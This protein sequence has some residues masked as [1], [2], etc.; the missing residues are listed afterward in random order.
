MDNLNKSLDSFKEQGLL[1]ESTVAQIKS[2]F[3]ETVAEATRAEISIREAQIVEEA[4]LEAYGE[5]EDVLAEKEKVIMAEADEYAKNIIEES[6]AKKVTE[7]EKEAIEYVDSLEEKY[8]DTLD[9][10]IEE[11]ILPELDINLLE[12]AMNKV[13]DVTITKLTEESDRLVSKLREESFAKDK[14]IEDLSEVISS[15]NTSKKSEKRSIAEESAMRTLRREKRRALREESV[16]DDDGEFDEDYSGTLFNEDDED[17]YDDGYG[18]ATENHSEESDI[19]DDTKDD[20]AARYLKEHEAKNDKSSDEEI[21]I[22]D[23]EEPEIEIEDDE[24]SRE[25]EEKEIEEVHH[26]FSKDVD[27]YTE[28]QGTLAQLKN[29]KG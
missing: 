28:L 15:M 10:I 24:I 22:E 9:A 18:E 5:L 29:K 21:E 13:E 7:L 16:Y 6:V 1:E 4:K 27:E 19:L 2:E 12:T 3:N 23:E 26:D 14:V 20:E 11:S 17:N 8:V 25:D